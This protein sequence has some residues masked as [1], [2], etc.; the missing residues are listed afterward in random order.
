LSKLSVKL[1]VGD[2]INIKNDFAKRTN[3]SK[4]EFILKCTKKDQQWFI[5]ILII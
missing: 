4:T 2:K 3:V 1:E 5:L